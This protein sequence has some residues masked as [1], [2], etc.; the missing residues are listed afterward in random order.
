MLVALLPHAAYAWT[1]GTHV[2]LGEAVLRS[3]AQ[4][5][6]MVGDLLR[7]FPYDFLYGSIA[8]DTSLA[9]KYVPTGR[10]C[11]SWNVGLEIH[12]AAAHQWK[13]EHAGLSQPGKRADHQTQ[14]ERGDRDQPRRLATNVE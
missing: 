8:A 7:A 13:V 6:A 9:K 1:P 2:Y 4:L 11:H 5:P 14:R 10:H 12:A 3:L